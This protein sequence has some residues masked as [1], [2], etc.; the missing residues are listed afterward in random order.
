MEHQLYGVSSGNGNMGVSHIFADYY[1]R[2]NDPWRLATLAMVSQFKEQYVKDAIEACEVDGE[3]EYT[4]TACILEPLDAVPCEDDDC[5]HDD[6]SYSNVNGAAH[7]IHVF[8]DDKPR[9]GR[10]IYDNLEDAFD[11]ALMAKVD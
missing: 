2:T 8:P 10:P 9:E 1:V 6:C 11:A 5:T 4:V 7:L 3:P